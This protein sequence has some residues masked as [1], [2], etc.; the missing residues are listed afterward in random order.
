MKRPLLTVLF[1]MMLSPLFSQPLGP[2]YV[3]YFTDKNNSPYSIDNPSEFL[4]EAAIDRRNRQGIAIQVD[5]IP[6]NASYLNAVSNA[7]AQIAAV[8][9][10]F[11][12]AAVWIQNP[13]II[14]GIL[15]LPFVSEV[16][17]MSG[18]P[19]KANDKSN[20][21]NKP[22]FDS[23]VYDLV[24]EEPI[25]KA[26]QDNYYNYGN[27]D[28]QIEMVSG[29]QLHNQGYRGEGMV[30][31]VLDAGFRNVDV[32]T[33]FDSLRAN[34][35]IL[36]TR[37]FVQPGNNV[38][39]SW[40]HPHGTMVLSIMGANLPGLM[41]GTAPEAS[42]WLLRTED[43]NGPPGNSE[44][45][46]EEYF[47]I[48]GAEFA[49]SVGAWI[50]NSSL[51]YSEFDD[52]T[53]NHF[54]SDLNGNTIPITLGADRAASKGIFVVNSAGN[55]GGSAW[56]YII[57]PSDGHKVMAVG[58]VNSS[59]NYASFS[60]TGPT[61]DGRIKPDIS[62]QGAGTSFVGSNGNV[63]AGNGTSFSSPIIAGMA[64]CLWQTNMDVTR[65]GVYEAIIQSGS[66]YLNPDN[67]LGN[68]IPDFEHA[69]LILTADNNLQ[70]KTTSI[71]AY[72]NPAQSFL[73][74][75][76]NLGNPIRQILITDITGKI[77]L[78][79]DFS[80]TPQLKY[81]EDLSALEAGV[82]ILRIY[83]ATGAEAVKI[84]KM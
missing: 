59:G 66:Q 30:I 41:V 54:Y 19:V 28:N 1:L 55:S 16:S 67:F 81:T 40:I 33:A 13:N 6:V 61:A 42:Y 39:S 79:R 62:A 2:A 7:G 14:P 4:T 75:E 29:K 21:K 11:N 45:L 25:T 80:N 17:P 9:R 32:I 51:G 74:I 10:W 15:A 57:A 82:Y 52:P 72:P 24:F 73:V 64:A 78:S 63:N 23:E 26:I 22:F 69:Q 77:K 12:M 8:S 84:I 53:Q 71:K 60:S 49:D 27:A 35:R 70:A 43:A 18:G 76:S 56:Q 44:Y 83:T 65:N 31:A 5:D 47:W 37:D 68:G 48:S 36:G 38:Y 58:A 50:I 20:W 34:N 3:I 46:M